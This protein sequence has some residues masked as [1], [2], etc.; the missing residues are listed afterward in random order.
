MNSNI[1][2]RASEIKMSKINCHCRDQIR[3]DIIKWGE[4]AWK[5]IQEE[6]GD[7]WRRLCHKMI[8]TG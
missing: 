3:E 1:P 7:V 6:D 4:K 2:L 5:Q 8:Q